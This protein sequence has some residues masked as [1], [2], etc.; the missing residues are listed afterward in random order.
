M[1]RRRVVLERE[2]KEEGEVLAAV[3]VLSA[4]STEMAS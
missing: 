1:L 3:E 4:V 2:L